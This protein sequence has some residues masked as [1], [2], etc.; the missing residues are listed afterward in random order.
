MYRKSRKRGEA[1]DEE[2][3]SGEE[4]EGFAGVGAELVILAQ[5]T[6]VAEPAEGA[7]DYPAA[8]KNLKAFLGVVAAD[9]F[10]AKWAFAE[11]PGYP[12]GELVGG[13]DARIEDQSVGFHQP[14]AFAC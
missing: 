7:F 13:V 12:A 1:G 11:A 2:E 4:D 14:M 10:Q 6:E 9:G 3:R 5:A 8:G